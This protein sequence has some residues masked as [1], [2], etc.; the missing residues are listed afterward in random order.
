VREEYE[1]CEIFLKALAELENKCDLELV[2][3]LVE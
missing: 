1:K 2:K 3:K